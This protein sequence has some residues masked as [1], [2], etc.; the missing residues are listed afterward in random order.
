MARPLPGIQ[1]KVR[2]RPEPEISKPVPALIQTILQC[3]QIN[4]LKFLKLPKTAKIWNLLRFIIKKNLPKRSPKLKI[5]LS[6]WL[7]CFQ[8]LCRPIQR[9]VNENVSNAR[10]TIWQD[11]FNYNLPTMCESLNYSSIN[12]HIFLYCVLCN[13]KYRLDY[14]VCCAMLQLK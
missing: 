1:L 4:Y 9:N 12:M 10:R 11:R 13:I 8:I 3:D 2:A 7:S 14:L 5:R 6:H